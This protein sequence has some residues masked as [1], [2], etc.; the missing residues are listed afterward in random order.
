MIIPSN[1]WFSLYTLF[2]AFQHDRLDQ[3]EVGR[4]IKLSCRLRVWHCFSAFQ[5]SQASCCLASK[6]VFTLYDAWSQ[7]KQ[8]GQVPSKRGAGL[9]TGKALLIDPSQRVIPDT[10]SRNCIVEAH[11][12]QRQ[13]QQIPTSTAQ[14]LIHIP[15]F[16][17]KV[18]TFSINWPLEPLDWH[19]RNAQPQHP[20]ISTCHQFHHSMM[21]QR[22]RCAASSF[23]SLY[24]HIQKSVTNLTIQ[25]ISKISQTSYDII[26]FRFRW[27]NGF[28]GPLPWPISFSLIWVEKRPNTRQCQYNRT[29]MP[30]NSKLCL[31]ESWRCWTDYDRF[32]KLKTIYVKTHIKVWSIQNP[33]ALICWF[34]DNMRNWMEFIHIQPYSCVALHI[35][36]LYI[37]ISWYFYDILMYTSPTLSQ[38]CPSAMLQSWS[39]RPPPCLVWGPSLA[40]DQ[41]GKACSVRIDDGQKKMML[42][43]MFFV[44]LHHT[45]CFVSIKIWHL[46]HLWEKKCGSRSYSSSQEPTWHPRAHGRLEALHRFLGDGRPAEAVA[47]VGMPELQ[48]RLWDP[49]RKCS[50]QTKWVGRT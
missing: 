42:R 33:C 27:S 50:Y 11:I 38:P 39:I 4:E 46:L 1:S 32:P 2:S 21:S 19:N 14:E 49:K 34:A 36:Q 31:A 13:Y 47:G 24:L 41:L 7:K 44:F 48:W 25:Q 23:F 26:W 37:D 16:H 3:L 9:K 20:Q 29:H 12:L 30:L 18:R 28:V 5:L 35:I 43:K 22:I 15:R 17:R 10:A 8:R 45:V 40:L 6:H